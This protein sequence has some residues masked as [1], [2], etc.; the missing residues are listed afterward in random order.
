M[1]QKGQKGIVKVLAMGL[2]S[3]NGR[4]SDQRGEREADPSAAA[5]AGLKGHVKRSLT[6][7]LFVWQA[8]SRA[9]MSEFV[10][11]E[12][13]APPAEAASA[14]QAELPTES[15][16]EARLLVSCPG[17]GGEA[18]EVLH[19]Y[20][21]ST[22]PCNPRVLRGTN[23]VHGQVKVV[24]VLTGEELGLLE[25]RVDDVPAFASFLDPVG[26]LSRIVTGHPNGKHDLELSMLARLPSEDFECPV[27]SM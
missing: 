17:R 23:S 1:S 26:G 13:R 4:A 22:P 10:Q 2:R 12:E 11:E 14:S 6:L 18:L 7:C 3:R 8:C 27:M 19:A 20:F 21:P 9:P 16:P 15:E 25:E 5:E 24:D